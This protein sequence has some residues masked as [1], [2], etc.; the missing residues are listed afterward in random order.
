[1]EQRNCNEF[2]KT[3]VEEIFPFFQKPQIE[4]FQSKKDEFVQCLNGISGRNYQTAN[5]SYIEFVKVVSL[6]LFKK[7]S[8]IKK[9][10]EGCPFRV[11][12][13]KRLSKK[14]ILFWLNRQNEFWD[15]SEYSLMHN[16]YRITYNELKEIIRNNNIGVNRQLRNF[17]DFLSTESRDYKT[18]FY[19]VYGEIKLQKAKAIIREHIYYALSDYIRKNNLDL[20]FIL[21]NLYYPTD[22]ERILREFTER[23]IG[24]A[25]TLKKVM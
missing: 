18:Q 6:S 15:Y 4:V 21:K 20:Y 11:E 24:M 2:L 5:E 23:K 13:P 10:S 22:Y 7:G 8:F 16:K 9:T 14:N 19:L 12:F 25:E 1:M 3:F 17:G